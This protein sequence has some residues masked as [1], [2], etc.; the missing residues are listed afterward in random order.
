MVPAIVGIQQSAEE[1]RQAE[2]RRA[3]SRLQTL[4]PEQLAAV[5]ALTRG[6]MNKFLHMPLQALKTAAREGDAATVEAICGVFE[7]G[8]G[9]AHGAEGAAEADPVKGTDAEKAGESRSE[10][11][12]AVAGRIEPKVGA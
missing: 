11:E 12:H 2:L 9:A 10:Q 3:H 4:T 5:E 8:A 6:M 7:G 1:I